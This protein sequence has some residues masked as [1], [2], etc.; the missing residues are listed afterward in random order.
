MKMVQALWKVIW[1]F[2]KKLENY[3]HMIQQLSSRAVYIREDYRQGFEQIN[4]YGDVCNYYNG[5]NQMSH[6]WMNG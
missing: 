6:Q 2:L 5:N 1:Q 4:V 3:H